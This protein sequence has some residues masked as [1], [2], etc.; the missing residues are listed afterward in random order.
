MLAANP[1]L[2]AFGCAAT[3]RNRNSSR[4]GKL[5]KIWTSQD[6]SALNGCSVVTYLLEKGRVTHHAPGER[7]FHVFYLLVAAAEAGVEGAEWA[8]MPSLGVTQPLRF[9]RHEAAQAAAAAAPQD[10]TALA[11]PEELGDAAQRAA[12]ARE[13]CD[14]L[15]SLVALGATK[16]EAG[17]AWRLLAAIVA[18]GDLGFELEEGT[19][20]KATLSPATDASLDAAAVALGVLPDVLQQRLLSRT[21]HTGRGSSYVIRFDV[22]AAVQGRDG[23][24]HDLYLR[25]FAWVVR[26]VNRSLDATS[27]ST[28]QPGAA[29]QQAAAVAAVVAAAEQ[30]RFI[31]ILDIFGFEQLDDNSLE[32][33]LIN[34]TNERLQLFF[35]GQTL[36]AEIAMYRDEGVPVPDVSTEDNAACVALVEARPAGL[37]WLI[38]DECNLPK[39][40]D[41]SLVA[42]FFATHAEHE[43]LAQPR[44]SK[45]RRASLVHASAAPRFAVAHYAA[46]VVYEASGFLHKNSDALH[47]EL[48]VFLAEGGNA[49]LA[50]MYGETQGGADGAGAEAAAPAAAEGGKKKGGRRAHF[51]TARVRGVAGSFAKQLEEL[52]GMLELTTPHYVRCVKP[53]GKQSAGLVEPAFVL[54]QL[55]CGGTPQ[56]LQLMGRGYP[57]RCEYEQ[58]AA[59]YQPYLPVLAA[60]LSARDFAQALL[61]A[62]ELTESVNG[63]H[64]DYALGVRRVFFSAGKMATLDALMGGSEAEMAALA[65]R[66]TRW[67]ARR[68]WRRAAATVRAALRLGRHVCA[69]RNLRLLVAHTAFI[70][71]ARRC[72]VPWLQRARLTRSRRAAAT[73]L[74]AAARGGAARRAW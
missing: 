4:F 73:V 53:N 9:L 30:R 38:E 36:H 31:A 52:M 72:A 14:V 16:E 47:A 45:K 39:A 46:T 57:T 67:V 49:L 65:S 44:A 35:L 56:L 29:P 23:L 21:V 12:Q 62:L 43:N 8:S 5:M 48:P 68:R 11:L 19:D 55:R 22:D 74:Q 2:E 60:S 50:Q 69:W 42:R 20:G 64:A 28:L 66:V 33:L 63:H 7:T 32:Q 3:V 6:S 18:L 71:H 13:F 37:V 25:L 41:A 58:I 61:A 24:A 40:T 51:T 54:S 27:T 17:A 34:H 10:D 70:V 15:A 59:R 1:V 26:V